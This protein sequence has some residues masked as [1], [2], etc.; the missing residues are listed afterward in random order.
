MAGEFIELQR[1][2]RPAPIE[3]DERPFRGLFGDGLK[4]DGIWSDL[5]KKRRVIILAEAGSGK[6]SEFKR[7][8][9]SLRGDGKFAFY[10]SVRDVT[11]SGLESA[12]PAADRRRFGEWRADPDAEC[13]F[14]IDS[15][16]EAKD[17]G[18][19]FDSAVR[20]LEFAIAGFEPRVHLY[21][22]NRFTDWDKTADRRSMETWLALPEPPP[23]PPDLDEEVR[24][25]LHNREKPAGDTVEDIAV[26]P[27]PESRH[28]F[29]FDQSSRMG[30]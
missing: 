12:L 9:Q 27:M 18:H 24:A 25:T 23:A 3:D 13:W 29:R 8:A 22:S 2:F 14:F 16:D 6:S 20:N 5:L 10:A 28:S 30:L 7:Q 21:I 15:V 19:H 4:L 26:L 11:Q 17:Q 1:H